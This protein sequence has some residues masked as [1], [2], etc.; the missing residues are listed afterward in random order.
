MSYSVS[1]ITTLKAFLDAN[2]GTYGA[3]SDQDAAVTLNALT[4]NRVRSSMTGA[5]VFDN[6]DSTE[7]AA[8]TDSQKS[9]VLSLCSVQSVDPAN[10]KPAAQ[11]IIDIFGNPSTT[12]TAL[13]AAR[14]ETV[15]PATTQGLPRARAEDVRRARLL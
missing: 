7:F 3:L 1:Q 6:V 9:Q 15:S 2:A 11:I 4:E 5:E 14:D 13:L 12:R 8:L 10:A